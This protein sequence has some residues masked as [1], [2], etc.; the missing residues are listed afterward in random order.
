MRGSPPCAPCSSMRPPTRR[1]ASP[2]CRQ[3]SSRSPCPPRLCW[4][5]PQL[6]N[7]GHA[8]LAS[9]LPSEQ[10]VLRPNPQLRGPLCH[11]LMP[12]PPP[13]CLSFP[14]CK[15][16]AVQGSMVCVLCPVW[17]LPVAA[18]S[19]THFVSWGQGNCLRARDCPGKILCCGETLG[20][21]VLGPAGRL[22]GTMTREGHPSTLLG[23]VSRPG[24]AEVCAQ[25]CARVCWCLC[26]CLSWVLSVCTLMC[27]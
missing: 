16:E 4:P 10:W 1:R 12:S 2:S 17:P 25:V 11:G 9:V 6:P 24:R 15:V 8:C 7:P 13:P 14:F 5:S 26:L 18:A 27:F 22:P 3:R 20:K 23:P 21:T 19:G